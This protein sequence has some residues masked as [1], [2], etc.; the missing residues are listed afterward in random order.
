MRAGRIVIWALVLL[1]VAPEALAGKRENAE[2][3][4]RQALQEASE[5]GPAVSASEIK[6]LARLLE[7]AGWEPTPELSGVFQP[8]AIFRVTGASHEL[9]AVDCVAAT[10]Q[11]NPYTSADLVSSMQAGVS[12]DAGAGSAG[13]GGQNIK[14]VKFGAP[15][16]SSLPIL[17]LRLEVDC[18]ARLRLLPAEQQAASY[19]VR[20]VLRAVIAEQTSGQLNAEGRLIGL[21]AADAGYAASSN[22]A[23]LEPV[24]V[25]YRRVPLVELLE[26]TPPAATANEL[27]EPATPN[28]ARS[29]DSGLP[30]L[31]AMPTA[32]ESAVRASTAPSSLEEPVEAPPTSPR[33]LVFSQEASSCTW[34]V[35]DLVE[36]RSAH[37]F[38]SSQCPRELVWSGTEELFFDDGDTYYSLHAGHLRAEPLRRPEHPVCV[39]EDSWLEP[40]MDPRSG[41][42]HWACWAEAETSTIIP[43]DAREI[44]RVCIGDLC[45]EDGGY[46]GFGTPQLLLDFALSPSGG[47]TL[48]GTYSDCWE[49]E[50]CGFTT[51]M[52]PLSTSAPL[53]EG[54][55]SRSSITS[56]YVRT[57]TGGGEDMPEELRDDPSLVSLMGID[58]ELPGFNIETVSPEPVWIEGSSLG[59]DGFLLWTRVEGERGAWGSVVL[60]DGSCRRRQRLDFGMWTSL[61]LELAGRWAVIGPDSE[62][63]TVL[64][65]GATQRVERTWSANQQVLVLPSGVPAPL[66][67]EP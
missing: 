8:G 31:E 26:A 62:G 47:W 63:S 43:G 49:T 11:E 17:D 14:M 38:A 25:G 15:T 41:T 1:V 44:H 58:T 30:P 65:D 24:A 5:R 3:A 10:P 35:E 67:V 61:Q 2:Q 21:G 28:G 19:V 36:G 18:A 66:G 39:S 13:I 46:P 34:T 22:Q 57:A 56:D 48:D 12:V 7:K 59:G 29:V 52:G 54:I 9:L 60:C 16:Q 6:P 32:V 20:E 50:G 53:P 45:A 51:S 64:V 27:L 23:S 40:R 37:L 4:A 55:Y 33:V 42:I